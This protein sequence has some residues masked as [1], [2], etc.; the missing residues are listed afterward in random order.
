MKIRIFYSEVRIL[1]YLYS[2]EYIII[3]EELILEKNRIIMF[4]I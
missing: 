2:Y 1:Y 4:I 3:Y